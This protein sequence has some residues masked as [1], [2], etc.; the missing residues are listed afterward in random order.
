M[1]IYHNQSTQNIGRG[2]VNNYY[3]RQVA[4][5]NSG[6]TPALFNNYFGEQFN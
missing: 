4:L 3:Q 2:D 5:G 6:S 1:D